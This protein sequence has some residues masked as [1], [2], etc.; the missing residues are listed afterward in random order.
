M[1]RKLSWLPVLGLFLI[2]TSAKAQQYLDAGT[3]E[4]TLSGT[5]SSNQDVDSGSF[6]ISGS[7]GYFVADQLEIGVRQTVSYSDFNAGTNVNASTSV[8]LDY[9]FDLGQW[10]PFIGVSIG[11][12]YG[13]VS[14]SWFAGPEGGIKYFVKPETFI[15]GLVQYQYFF[16]Q[17]DGLVNNFDDGAFAYSIG[18]GFTW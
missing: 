8:L 7:L 3:W 12:T 11:Y 4:M 6:G 10:Q 9:H 13:D 17:G 2:P 15:Y 16:D 5:G 18:I 1:L 14:D